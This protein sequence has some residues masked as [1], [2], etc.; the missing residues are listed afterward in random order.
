MF[1]SL[2]FVTAASA[3]AFAAAVA[4]A[5]SSNSGSGEKLN[6]GDSL[7]GFFQY[8]QY[9]GDLSKAASSAVES[10]LAIKPMFDLKPIDSTS[11]RNESYTHIFGFEKVFESHEY[12]N[13]I[14]EWMRKN[15]KISITMALVYLVLVFLG[16]VYM[17]S[18]PKYELR[19]P[20]VIWN[21]FLAGFSILGTIRVWPDL[22]YSLSK[23]GFL[24]SV[25]DNSY[26]YGITGFWAYMFILSKVPELIDTMFI[27]LRKQELIF[28]HWYHHATVLVYCW[29][30]YKDLTASGRWFM[31]MN[32]SIH[33]LMYSYYA[34][35][36][37]RIRVPIFISQIITTGQLLQMVIGCYLNYVAWQTKLN[38]PHVKCEI[39][40]DNIKY[41]FIMYFSYFIL[42]FNFFYNAYI[43]RPKRA[44]KK[45][46]QM[47]DENGKSVHDNNKI[48]QN[49]G[50]HNNKKVD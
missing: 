34:C 5:V 27:V 42:F 44:T 22:L 6:N 48:P 23:D 20:L 37:M 25:C 38:S 17:R 39:S 21:L 40:E 46:A 4:T 28:L 1:K 14:N 9:M 12:V 35:K 31:S 29:Y 16:Q 43:V 41:S 32:Y 47:T 11:T 13:Q 36:A 50:D 24:H 49:P 26:A 15:W 2:S 45:A 7:L 18:R 19:I 10:F 33:A 8:D 3:T 30:S